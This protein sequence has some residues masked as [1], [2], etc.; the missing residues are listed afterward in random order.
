MGSFFDSI[1]D[2]VKKLL[3]SKTKRRSPAGELAGLAEVLVREFVNGSGFD[4]MPPRP[5]DP[6]AAARFSI[7]SKL[8]RLAILFH[9]LRA[10][11][12]TEPSFGDVRGMV[13]H[14]TIPRS[15]EEE[16]PMLAAINCAMKDMGV[17]LSPEGSNLMFS[18]SRDWLRSI[19]I[20]ENNP[21]VLGKFANE[22]TNIALIAT[23]MIRDLAQE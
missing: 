9:C 18:W 23:K 20:D 17:I 6:S 8:Y 12:K 7:K 22:W 16:A 15:E 14:L 11:E 19:E 10:K 13:E 21:A 5:L 2:G 1:G 4:V 3:G